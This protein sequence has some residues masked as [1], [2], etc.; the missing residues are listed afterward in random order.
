M[1][2]WEA[3]IYAV[4]GGITEILPISF[5]GHSILFEKTFHMSSLYSGDGPFIRAGICIGIVIALCIIFRQETRES[6]II[7]RR[8]KNGTLRSRNA[9]RDGQGL[10]MRVLLLCVIGFIPMIFS[11]F[12]LVRAE[13]LHKLT[14]IS[15]FFAVNGLLILIC[16]RGPVGKKSEREAT[17]YDMLL[18][19]FFRMASVFPGLSSTGTSLCVGRARGFSHSFNIR[20]TYTLTIALQSL[21]A[22]FFLFR[23]MIVGR[24]YSRTILSFLVAAF[25]SA[26]VAFL[27]LVTFRNMVLKNKLKAFMYYCFDAAAIAFI[28]AIING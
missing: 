25:V 6:Q 13:G 12:F 16:T 18:V 19:G 20:V 4:I 3:F 2:I 28:I 7:F 5:T 14:Y 27:A 15:C 17:L 10:K 9:R 21:L 22:V 11:L 24:F 8:I 23:G 1:R 26:V